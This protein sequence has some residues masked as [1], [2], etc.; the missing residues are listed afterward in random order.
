MS[1]KKLEEQKREKLFDEERR[2]K[3]DQDAAD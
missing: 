3:I 2:R 1:N